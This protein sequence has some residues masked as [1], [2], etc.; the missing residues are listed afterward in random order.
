M[1]AS[2]FFAQ[3]AGQLC[4]VSSKITLKIAGIKKPGYFLITRRKM[5]PYPGCMGEQQTLLATSL[6]E[7]QQQ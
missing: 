2:D 7:T 3:G 4:K 5:S 6:V 1:N